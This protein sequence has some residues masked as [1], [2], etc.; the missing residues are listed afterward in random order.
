[1]LDGFERMITI[2][3]VTK[4]NEIIP[5]EKI[6]KTGIISIQTNKNTKIKY[7]EE[8]IELKRTR[9]FTREDVI[10]NM[11]IVSEDDNVKLYIIIRYKENTILIKED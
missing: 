11:N 2:S 6:N 8:E 4:K 10:S 5:I 3:L 7:N 9:I 1:M